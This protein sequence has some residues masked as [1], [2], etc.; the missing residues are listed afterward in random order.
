MAGDWIKMRTDL[1]TNPKVVRI[2]SAMRADVLRVIG[3]LFAVWSVFDAHAEDGRLS[4]YTPDAMDAVIG[5]PGFTAAMIAVQWLHQESEPA[6]DACAEITQVLVAPGYSEHN[7]ATAKRR[8]EDTERK[9]SSRKS[10]T[11][12][13]SASQSVR[14]LS[15][16]AA[17][18][19]RTREEK[20]SN[21][22]LPPAAR[23]A[24]GEQ[25]L[26]LLTES[27]QVGSESSSVGLDDGETGDGAGVDS[28][29]EQPGRTGAVSLRTWL[30][31]C[32][33]DGEQPV[34]A[35]CAALRYAA[36][37]GLPDEVVALHWAEFKARHL[38][39]GAKR[40]RDWRRTLLNSIRDN[41][42]KLWRFDGHAPV[43]TSAG[44]QARVKRAAEMAA[45][46]G[47]EVAA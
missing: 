8:A 44:L 6:A 13:D 21:T 45:E 42:F 11:Q 35:G 16:N 18:K 24:G 37:I 39:A 36:D 34:P 7:G 22:P 32:H 29:V 33:A 31:A 43:L 20:N 19:K 30:D 10:D 15:A 2:S 38:E 47:A 1:R 14:N 41:W 40:Y 46:A 23:A 28:G 26:D 25:A 4:G 27:A 17:D 9:R 5:W 12:H 3:G